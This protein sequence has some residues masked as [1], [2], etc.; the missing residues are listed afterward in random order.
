MPSGGSTERSRELDDSPGAG[1]ASLSWQVGP[2][3]REP[4][5]DEMRRLEAPPPPPDVKSD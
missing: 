5:P 3:R 1:T 2:Q 4:N